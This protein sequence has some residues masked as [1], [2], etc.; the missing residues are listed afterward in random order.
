MLLGS[1]LRGYSS[2]SMPLSRDSLLLQEVLQL[3]V[4][5]TLQVVQFRLQGLSPNIFRTAR[6]TYI[7]EKFKRGGWTHGEKKKNR[8]PI[9]DSEILSVQTCQSRESSAKRYPDPPLQ[10]NQNCIKALRT[11]NHYRS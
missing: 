10:T 11:L 5:Q 6:F 4:F 1:L 8:T 3:N 9:Q 7:A 2:Y